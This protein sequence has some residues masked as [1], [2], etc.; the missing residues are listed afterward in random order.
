MLSYDLDLVT[1]CF[2][3][4]CRYLAAVVGEQLIDCEEVDLVTAL[5]HL[6]EARFL[7][8]DGGGWCADSPN[9]TVKIIISRGWHINRP[10]HV[11][12]E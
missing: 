3:R 12:T 6:H 11:S 7:V 2:V 4:L 1:A 8:P 10:G 5:P 9:Q